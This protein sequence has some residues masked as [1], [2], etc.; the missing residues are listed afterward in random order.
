MYVANVPRGR[1]W[2]LHAV[3][4]T[5]VLPYLKHVQGC[6]LVDS[7]IPQTVHVVS[8]EVHPVQDHSYVCNAP[9]GHMCQRSSCDNDVY[10]AGQ[11][12]FAC[13]R[14][15]VF[16]S[17]KTAINHHFRCLFMGHLS[18]LIF[19]FYEGYHNIC[20]LAYIQV[21]SS[22]LGEGSHRTPKVMTQFLDK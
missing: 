17:E 18:F 15:N 3:H 6:L 22:V 16:A 14:L 4:N 5:H 8:I 21:N 2:L 11:K 13:R 19:K 10:P 1:I 9:W 12:S 20:I 7:S